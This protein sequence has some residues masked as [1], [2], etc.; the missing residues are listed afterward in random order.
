MHMKSKFFHLFLAAALLLPFTGISES[1]AHGD[2]T[3]DLAALVHSQD[4]TCYFS[5][6][7]L[8]V[9]DNK[10]YLDREET[11]MDVAP[12][13][14]S[15]RTMLPIR[16]IAEA[17]GASID[18]DPADNSIIITTVYDDVIICSVGAS[19]M[20][21]NN[22]E[23]AIDSPAYISN[24]RTYLP[25][26]AVAEAMEFLVFWDDDSKTVTLTAPYQTARILAFAD[27]L[28]VSGLNA[29]E[30]LHDGNGMWV[31]QF[32]T[33]SGARS[34]VDFLAGQGIT[35]EPDSYIT[36]SDPLE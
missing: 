8:T 9:G 30:V 2:F 36:L 10:L 29:Q 31:I 17:V 11:Q 6:M 28:D 35:A 16:P 32:A 20:L 33:P 7:K 15:S 24:D 3:E 14:R 13:I 19:T 34:A 27:D 1:K 18:Y 26:R 21:I 22:E 12:E 5:E 23:V 25:L 4:S